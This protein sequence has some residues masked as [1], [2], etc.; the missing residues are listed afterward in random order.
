MV[1]FF[2]SM[3]IKMTSKIVFLRNENLQVFCLQHPRN[4]RIEILNVPLVFY[5]F[6]GG[7]EGEFKSILDLKLPKAHNLTST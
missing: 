6:H 4:P 2:S 7:I 1:E 3:F 5:G